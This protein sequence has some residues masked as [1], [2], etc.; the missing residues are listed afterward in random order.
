VP[1]R[2]RNVTL[3]YADKRYLKLPIPFAQQTKTFV[4]WSYASCRLSETDFTYFSFG[5]LL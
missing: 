1:T 3:R 2:R 4:I 5:E